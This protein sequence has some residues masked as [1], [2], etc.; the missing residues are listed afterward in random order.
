MWES[1]F[2]VKHE[3]MTKFRAKC[4]DKKLSKL[5]ETKRMGSAVVVLVQDG[6]GNDLSNIMVDYKGY[7]NDP[8]DDD[9]IGMTK[10]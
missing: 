7:A 9:L 10:I 1:K 4:A 2:F 5:T 8:S 6:N 3:Y